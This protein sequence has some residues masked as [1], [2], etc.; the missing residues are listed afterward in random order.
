ML[1]CIIKGTTGCNLS[2]TYCSVGKKE[3]PRYA[4]AEMLTASFLYIGALCR[5]RGEK[6]ANVIF[7]GGEPTLLSPDS[8]QTA[9]SA[10]Q[11]TYPELIWDFLMQTNGY[12][13]HEDWLYFLKKSGV[14]VGVS[15][16]GGQ[17]IHDQTRRDPQNRPT[18]QRVVHNIDAMLEREIPVSCLM[19]LTRAALNQPLD[20]LHF[21]AERR[22][23]LKI[24]PLLRCGEACEHPNLFL[25][26]G[27]YADYLIRCF[28]YRLKQKLDLM[29]APIDTIVSAILTG[30][31]VH[32]CTFSAGCNTNFLCIDYK[33]DI[34]PCGKFADLHDYRLGSIHDMKFDPL[35]CPSMKELMSRRTVALPSKCTKCQYL[36]LCHA[37]CNAE[38]LMSNGLEQP[39][40][41]CSDYRALFDFATSEGLTLLRTALLQRKNELSE[42]LHGI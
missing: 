15:I 2:C 24:N 1:T 16:D 25:K 26:D 31:P 3:V 27:E 38:A 29:I 42:A 33:G 34:Y 14:R 32:E 30:E 19:V 22:L 7:H 37:G 12:M 6:H 23:S 8:Y 41:L 9:I 11:N 13:L 40:A 35:D 4:T 36:N 10:A 39:S 28:S 20:Y 21:F 18:F 5:R 17:S